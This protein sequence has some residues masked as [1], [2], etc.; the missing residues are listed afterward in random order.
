MSSHGHSDHGRAPRGLSQ[1][2]W[3]LLVITAALLGGLAAAA[4]VHTSLAIVVIVSV[5]VAGIAVL[6]VFRSPA[7]PP[8]LPADEQEDFGRSP[9]PRPQAP[10][11]AQA[12]RAAPPAP[13]P[14]GSG[15]AKSGGLAASPG[16]PWWDSA[17]GAQPPPSSGARRAPAPDL[18]TYLASTIIAQCPHCGAFG[19]DPRQARSGWDLRCQS[20]EYTWAWQPGTSWPLVTSRPSVRGARRPSQAAD[21]DDLVRSAFAELVQP[22]RLL[23]NPPGRMELGHTE[24]VEVRLT[25]TLKMD[26][27]LL[28][29]LRGHGEPQVEEIPTAPLM[30]VT[31][32]GDG[33][34]ITSY[35]DEEQSV[36]QDA[37]TTWE[38]DIRALQQGQ[39][40]L[41][42]CVS[43]RIPVP[44][45]PLEH[46]SIPVR[47]ATIEVQVGAL[48]L[49]ASSY[50]ATGNG[51]S[52]P[53]LPSS[54]WS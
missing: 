51:S 8:G 14:P 21:Y 39:Q 5:V 18:S 30:A 24:R 11:W 2:L 9:A 42:M 23:F 31:L 13:G 41:I 45:Q 36:T 50:L 1:V 54:Q 37:I 32:K 40:L 33:F 16:A 53:P 52:V 47:E 28:E 19:L 35:S 43:L 22:G 38:F 12:P 3:S 27:E 4:L 29:H 7:R 10:L 46:K 34:Q 49:A 44:G 25:R 26:A 48:A 15:Q 20:C 17:Q 6:A